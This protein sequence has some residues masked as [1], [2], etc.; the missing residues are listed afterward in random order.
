LAEDR[1]R[2]GVEGFLTV[3]DARRRVFQNESDRIAV[4]RQR[5]ETRVDL[6]LALGGGFELDPETEYHFI[7]TL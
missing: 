4:R 6:H 3:L 1:Y 7:L 5:L 2:Q